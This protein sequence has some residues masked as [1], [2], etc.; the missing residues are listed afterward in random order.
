M[1]KRSVN[2]NFDYIP[3]IHHRFEGSLLKTSLKGKKILDIGCWTGQFLSLIEKDA[4]TYGIDPDKSAIKFANAHRRGDFVVGTALK[5]PYKKNYFDVVTMWDVIEHIPPN[6]EVR[7]L[8]EAA[9][10]LRKGGLFA[11]GTVTN[12][13]VSILLDPA[14]FLLGHRHYSQKQLHG[15]MN[16]TGFRIGKTIY[17]GGLWA[18]IRENINLLAKH[19]FGRN[20]NFLFLERLVKSEYQGKGFYQIDIFATKL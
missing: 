1:L 4:K 16:R 15:L 6:T 17:S 12:H 7:A 18:L 14:Y 3:D 19:L 10:V 20:I 13:P 11:L 8:R 2:Y 9:R 5:L